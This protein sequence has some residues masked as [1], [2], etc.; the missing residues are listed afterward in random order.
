MSKQLAF[1]I[2]LKRCIGCDTC[3]VGCKVENAVAPGRFRLKVYDSARHPE[4][5][6]PRGTYPHLSQYWLPAMCHHCIEAPC[7][8][9]CPTSTLYRRESD[10]MVMLE[11][12]R[13]VGCL[14]CAEECPYDALSFDEALGTADKCTMCAHRVEQYQAPSCAVVCP[15]RAIHFG[16]IHDPT[17]KVAQL[18][19]TREH[20]VLAEST[21]AKP[22][23]YYLEP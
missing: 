23:I 6:H 21:G 11:A 9:A 14:R 22:Q 16:D 4:L 7:V 13:C 1:V 12:E 3:V 10:G 20:K 5:E 17:S 2:D 8:K 18:L 19:A 15:T